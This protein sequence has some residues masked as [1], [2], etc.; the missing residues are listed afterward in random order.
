MTSAI[1]ALGSNMGDRLQYLTRAQEQIEK[2]IGEI[3]ARSGVIETK[4]YGYTDQDDFLNM[5]IAVDTE[6][7]ARALLETLLD[8]EKQLDR[9][10]LIHWGPRTIDL[11]I[12]FYGD[13]IIDEPDLHIP[14]IDF[15][16]R[17]F[18]LDPIAEIAPD[19]IDPRSGMMIQKIRDDHA[20]SLSMTT[21]KE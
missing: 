5:A 17:A 10:R 4:A 15:A 8:I 13:C 3:T 9:V 16:N 20:K 11:D 14:H 2:R 12:I 19:R 21:S 1:I 18:V 7:S 6:L